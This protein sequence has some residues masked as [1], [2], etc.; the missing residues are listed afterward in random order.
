MRSQGR[1]GEGEGGMVDRMPFPIRKQNQRCQ[2]EE[3]GM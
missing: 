3:F 1:G 2:G